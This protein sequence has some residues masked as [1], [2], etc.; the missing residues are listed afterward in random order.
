MT[1][2]SVADNARVNKLFAANTTWPQTIGP[3]GADP[4][5]TMADIPVVA[6]ALGLAPML[7]A[8]AILA[9][10]HPPDRH[11]AGRGEDRPTPREVASLLLRR[12]AAVY[13]YLNTAAPLGFAAAV[14]KKTKEQPIL[15]PQSLVE[16]GVSLELLRAAARARNDKIERVTANRAA[17]RVEKQHPAPREFDAALGRDGPERTLS[18]EVQRYVKKVASPGAKRVSNSLHY[19]T[20]LEGTVADVEPDVKDIAQRMGANER[21]VMTALLTHCMQSGGAKNKKNKHRSALVAGTALCMFWRYPGSVS[22]R[23]APLADSLRLMG[24]KYGVAPA[25]AKIY[26]LQKC[27]LLAAERR[28]AGQ[29]KGVAGGAIRHERLCDVVLDATGAVELMKEYWAALAGI[30]TLT[31]ALW[32]GV[33]SAPNLIAAALPRQAVGDIRGAVV[34]FVQ[35]ATP[36]QA[37]TQALAIS[38]EVKHHFER[39]VEV[40]AESYTTRRK[41]VAPRLSLYLGAQAY[42]ACHG[43]KTEKSEA[44]KSLRREG[45]DDE[46][47]KAIMAEHRAWIYLD[48]AKRSSDRAGLSPTK[49]KKT[50]KVRSSPS[51]EQDRDAQETAQRAQETA[52]LAR[53]AQRT[54]EGVTDELEAEVQERAMRFKKTCA[55]ET[56][57][58][59]VALMSPNDALRQLRSAVGEEE[60][61]DFLGVCC[62][63]EGPPLGDPQAAS[64][65]LHQCALA[66]GRS[67]SQTL[68]C[69]AA[70]KYER[71]G[72]EEARAAGRHAFTDMKNSPGGSLA[73]KAAKKREAQDGTLA[74][75]ATKKRAASGGKKREAQDGTLAA[76]ATKKRAA[77]GGKKREAQDGTLAATSDVKLA[78]KGNSP[79]DDMPATVA[80]EHDSGGMLA[81]VAE[82]G[83]DGTPAATSATV[84]GGRPGVTLVDLEPSDSE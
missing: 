45:V 3:A 84:G 35:G 40:V 72:G 60:V 78:E 15:V 62:A 71:T 9:R 23:D 70:R 13:V 26:L 21:E 22:P 65:Y 48:D 12:G 41:L 2:L 38:R 73:A 49:S 61:K 4:S 79:G 36:A 6:N 33:K 43:Q 83:S 64:E 25:V 51:R 28:A 31:D 30:A 47:L 27:E 5:Q 52:R 54:Q 37:R 53:L 80:E 74:A 59:R 55:S 34:R 56:L 8:Q 32:A 75:T 68:L 50:K 82:P 10:G 77:S 18:T 20:H 58:Q 19:V 17:A 16:H 57:L 81:R 42:L 63:E 39:P 67:L 69:R 11:T 24:W 1:S 66:T 29:E 46:F 44:I 7:V 76:T 14:G